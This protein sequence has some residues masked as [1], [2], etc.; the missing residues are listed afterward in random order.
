MSETLLKQISLSLLALVF[1]LAFGLLGYTMIGVPRIV[2]MLADMN[3]QVPPLT[4]LAIS[5]TKFVTNPVNIILA[6]PILGLLAVGLILKESFMP[7]PARLGIN[8]ALALILA[9]LLALMIIAMQLPLSQ[10][11]T[12]R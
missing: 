9:V 4:L 5:A 10:V 11:G 12:I 7:V 8:G 6:L 1:L 2:W 3:I